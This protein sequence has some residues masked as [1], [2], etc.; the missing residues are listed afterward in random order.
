MF[1]S[2]DY[3][4]WEYD[5]ATRKYFRYQEM[6]DVSP[7]SPEMY[8]PLVD[9][10]TNQQ[11]NTEN[12]VIL[13]VRHTF[14]NDFNAED[15]VYNIDLITSGNAVVFRDGIAIPARW[16]RTEVDQPLFLTTL[17]GDPIFLRPGRTFYEVLGASSTYYQDETGW[18]YHFLTP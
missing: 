1:S 3:H 12:V 2:R 17:E 9:A 14:A 16:L 6:S 10:G 4:Y 15:E 13:F 5:P 18:H 11:V 7:T 8:M